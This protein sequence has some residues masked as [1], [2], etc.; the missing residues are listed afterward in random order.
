MQLTERRHL[1]MFPRQGVKSV[2]L[3]VPSYRCPVLREIFCEV[4]TFL[5]LLPNRVF[6]D[7]FL[8]L[9]PILLWIFRVFIQLQRSRSPRTLPEQTEFF[10]LLLVI[11]LLSFNSCFFYL[12]FSI[13]PPRIRT[14]GPREVSIFQDLTLY[15]LALFV[16][17]GFCLLL[18][19]VSREATLLFGG[20]CLFPRHAR[21]SSGSKGQSRQWVP[22]TYQRHREV[23]VTFNQIII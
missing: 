19:F 21:V 9:R 15:K 1:P 17:S 6:T 4:K 8:V 22:K 10:L 13:C 7:L 11:Q 23:N 3:Q 16:W 20:F 14:M 5:F 2:R 18:L 12:I